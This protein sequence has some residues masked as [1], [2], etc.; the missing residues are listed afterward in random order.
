MVKRNK[1]SLDL[2]R[3]SITR[4]KRKQIKDMTKG[5]FLCPTCHY[6]TLH[7]QKR[8]RLIGQGKE[9]SKQNFYSFKC[10]KCGFS[11]KDFHVGLSDSIS[12][13]YNRLVDGE[14]VVNAPQA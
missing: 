4:N 2:V 14:L 1:T 6:P 3:D 5:P 13:S 12:D 9:Q 7:G 10:S 11:A 8:F